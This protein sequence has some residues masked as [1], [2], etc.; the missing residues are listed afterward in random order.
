MK[1]VFIFWDNSNIF[2][3]AKKVAREKEGVDAYNKVRISFPALLNLARANRPLEF[4]VAVG[5]IP[6]AL[7]EVWKKLEKSGVKLDL[8][9]RGAQSRKE[10]AV[11]EVLQ[12][13]MLRKALDYNGNSGVAV[14]LTGDGAGFLDGA[15]F[16]ADLE[17]MQKKGWG[18]E[19]L[20][21]DRDCNDRFRKWAKQAGVF[22]RLEDFYE[23]ITF[24]ENYNG[25]I[26]PTKPLDLG[27]RL[28][29]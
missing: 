17:R 21:W 11:D 4:A 27:R 13:H 2:I 26:R 3:T 16:H 18:I 8:Y 22:V 14:V 28:I 12:V 7:R 29:V 23:S 20:A 10:Q 1:K 19:V 25:V 24:T 5:S 6:P 15:G 9:E